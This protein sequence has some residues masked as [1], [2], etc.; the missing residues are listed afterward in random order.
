VRRYLECTNE[1]PLRCDRLQPDTGEWSDG[2]TGR[3]FGDREASTLAYADAFRAIMIA[4]V[5]A[6]LLVPL[7]RNVAASKATSLDAMV[8][9]AAW[10]SLRRFGVRQ[11][12][13]E[14]V[15]RPI[16]FV[17]GDDQWGTDTDGV[18]VGILT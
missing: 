14:L 8:S 7:M 2:Q 4:F 10:R 5:I 18:V 6:T 11:G 12:R 1:F 15:E 9:V 3:R 16:Y 17:A 13:V